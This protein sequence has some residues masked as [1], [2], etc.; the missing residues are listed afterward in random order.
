MRKAVII[1]PAASEAETP[2]IS[3]C[4]PEEYEGM[5]K[6][7]KERGVHSTLDLAE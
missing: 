7:L 3:S 6:K 5:L 1:A 4:T 2:V